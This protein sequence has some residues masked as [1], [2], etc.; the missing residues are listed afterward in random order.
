M[1]KRS[2]GSI[3][4]PRSK[5]TRTNIKRQSKVITGRLEKQRAES[6]KKKATFVKH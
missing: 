6:H 3:S 2:R 5:R 4:K 1:V